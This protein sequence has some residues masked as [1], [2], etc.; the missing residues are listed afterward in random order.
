M[1]SE[2]GERLAEIELGLATH[3]K[4]VD[5][6]WAAQFLPTYSESIFILTELKKSLARE[7]VMRTALEFYEPLSAKA[8]GDG[9]IIKRGD[10]VEFFNDWDLGFRA[11]EALKAT[12][13]REAIAL[14][15][16]VL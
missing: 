2:L 9:T 5:K 16:R 7:N 4:S 12:D 3:E 14:L 15:D 13:L 11:R 10:V 1:M 8:T 6:E